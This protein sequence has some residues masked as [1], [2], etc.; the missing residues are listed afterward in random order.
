MREIKTAAQIG[1]GALGSFTAP[2]L[3]EALQD[4]FFV[5]AKGSRRERLNKDGI[6]VNG[7][8]HFFNVI[9]P[10]QYD[11][12]VDL[13][14][15]VVKYPQLKQALE[16]IR[17]LVGRDTIILPLLNGIESEQATAA[18]Y[19]WEHVLYALCQ[20][21]VTVKN[22]CAAFHPDAAV[23]RFGEAENDGYSEKVRLVKAVLD[24]SR[25]RYEIPRDMIRAQWQKF[26]YNISQ[27][28]SSA[29]LGLP[30]GAWVKSEHA[31]AIREAGMREV[32]A[33]AQAMGIDLREEDIAEQRSYLSRVSPMNKTSMLQDIENGRKTEV[34]QL[35]GALIPLA[36]KY[37]VPV[38]L[39]EFYYHAIKTLEE[40]QDGLF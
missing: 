20:I 19:G 36:R 21:S 29:V 11:R 24:R 5:V 16:D 37:N 35:A 2:Y 38:P 6:V 12:P 1:L 40:K 32:I 28:Q 8:R 22:G 26:M 23:L 39:N 14:F 13:I 4:Q 33:V 10:D 25:I 30:F 3:K 17:P 15:I 34:E 7:V 27:N 18:V 9:D 31:N